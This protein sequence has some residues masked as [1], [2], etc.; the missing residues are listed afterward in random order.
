MKQ[1]TTR[2]DTDEIIAYLQFDGDVEHAPRLSK[3][4]KE[5]LKRLYRCGELIRVYGTRNKVCP[6]LEKEFGISRQAADRDFQQCQTVFGTTL[7]SSKDFWLDVLLGFMIESRNKAMVKGD[8]RS[9]AQIEKNMKE[10]IKDLAGDEKSLPFDKVQPV[11]V[12][13][14]FFPELTKVKLPEDWEDQVKKLMKNK[15]KNNLDN[16][17]F[18]Q[19]AEIV[20]EDERDTTGA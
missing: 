7:K 2:S 19:D 3:K 9:V 10:A 8:M 11:Q 5:K 16:A 15:K 6:M 1:L 18:I 12:Q 4:L 13:I 14:G 20:E 17:D